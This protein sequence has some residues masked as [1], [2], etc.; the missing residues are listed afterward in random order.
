MINHIKCFAY[1]EHNNIYCEVSIDIKV[2][3]NQIE[4]VRANR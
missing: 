2:S 3:E 4:G 1:I